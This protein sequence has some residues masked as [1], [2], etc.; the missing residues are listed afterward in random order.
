[1]AVG[2]GVEGAEGGGVVEGGGSG[3][4]DGVGCGVVEERRVRGG[5][6]GR[7]RIGPG[8]RGGWWIGLGAGPE[9]RQRAQRDGLSVSRCGRQ[10]WG[11]TSCGG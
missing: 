3:R 1:V 6:G 10:G 7:W 2:A 11:E 4:V 5:C 9:I 8:V